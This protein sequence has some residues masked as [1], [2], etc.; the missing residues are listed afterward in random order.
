MRQTMKVYARILLD[1]HGALVMKRAVGIIQQQ[2]PA[3]QMLIAIGAI[4]IIA[5]A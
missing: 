1:A 4:I 2:Q 5:Q 3:M